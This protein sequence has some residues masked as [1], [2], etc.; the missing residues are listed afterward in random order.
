[1]PIY[2]CIIAGRLGR[3]CIP[4]P[5]A[6]PLIGLTAALAFSF[7]CMSL[8]APAIS[9]AA[10]Q[11]TDS[12]LPEG[13]QVDSGE[14]WLDSIRAEWGG[15]LKLRC[16]VSWPGTDSIFEPVGTGTFYDGNAQFRLINKILLGDWGYFDTHYELILSGG[17]TWKKGRAL[18]AI[19][20][21]A[22]EDTFLLGG[23]VN[24]DRRLFDLSTVIKET[25]EYVLYGRVDR[26]FLTLLPEWGAVR[27]GRQAITW[28]N[29][30]LFNPMD[31]FNPFSPTDIDREYKIGDDMLA[32]Q[33]RISEI[34]DVQ[35]LY[36]PR[37]DPDSGDPR[38]SSSS[39]AG[40]FHF[41]VG[42]TEFDL[43]AAGHY[44]DA[45]VGVGS[46]GY[47]GG[48]AW[49]ADATWTLL[50]DKDYR[51]GFVSLVANVDYSWTWWQKNL[52]G[53]LEFFY[54]GVGEDSYTGA[55]TD[56]DIVERLDRGELFT[57]GK[58]YLSG[59]LRIELHPLFN[60]F[61]TIINNVADPSG[62]LQPR[63]VWDVTEDVQLI[64]G[65]NIFFGRG[66]TEFGGFEVPGTDLT[67]AP[68]NNVYLWLNYYF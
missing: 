6:R 26:L 51:N 55:L 36:V 10:L 15:Y 8:S 30:M 43:M 66:G 7:F 67:N 62:I 3:P 64:F 63:G 5:T 50:Q 60:V 23:P 33:A 16:F 32:V 44:D 39:V 65:S 17:D 13:Q 53:F 31:L 28:G 49:R 1:W 19:F 11:A 54:S 18:N 41:T 24:D 57:L 47:V 46:V 14:N 27:I 48:A 40:K 59:S 21:V 25:N 61:F 68:P 42:S 29:G 37:N 56:P 22:F 45:V 20:P 12:N 35:F 4:L 52:Y 38:W 34:G 2:A 9:S 58:Y